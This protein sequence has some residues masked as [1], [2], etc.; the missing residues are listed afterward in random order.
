MARGKSKIMSRFRNKILSGW[1]GIS[2]LTGITM[3]ASFILIARLPSLKGQDVV[4]FIIYFMMAGST[5]VVA[6]FFL[7]WGGQNMI[8]IWGF[9]ILFRIIMVS[10]SP[11]LSDDVYRYIWDGNLVINEVN[12]YQLSVD[13]PTLDP[14]TIPTRDL[15]NHN[16][17]AS[18]Y[19]PMAQFFFGLVYW[20][21]PGSVKAFQVAALILDLLAGWLVMDM[22]RMLNLPASRLLIYL[23]NPL[24][25]VEFAHGAHVDALMLFLTMG[26]LWLLVKA[27]LDVKNKRILIWGSVLVLVGALLTKVVPILLIPLLIRRWSWRK[28]VVFCCLA[29]IF[30]AIFA[31]GAGWGLGGPLDGTG[32]FG[33]LRIY[34]SQW[35]Y[36]GGLYHWLEAWLTGYSTPGAVPADLVDPNR[37]ALAKGIM[38]ALLGA[39]TLIIGW[40]AWRNHEKQNGKFVAQNLSTLR[41]AVAIFGVYLLFSV[42]VHPWY[43]TIIV[44]LLPFL[45]PGWD[46]SQVNERFLWPW[47]TFSILVVLSYKTYIDVDN[48]REFSDIRLAEYIPLFLLLGWAGIPSIK[49]ALDGFKR[50]RLGGI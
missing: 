22:L 31:I 37:I 17:M 23:W 26:G 44:P 19:L 27:G 15:V 20:I 12:P 32:I 2:L 35:N 34:L 41:H 6:V 3:A 43:V 11:S 14:Y 46:E 1:G 4:L 13:S 18:P 33:A 25:I 29:L 42:T 36:N 24:V 21:S 47:L 45:L 50:K 40:S 16:W 5:Y 8:M 30:C 39:A 28:L 49:K 7:N 9:A 10:T 38:T 48:L